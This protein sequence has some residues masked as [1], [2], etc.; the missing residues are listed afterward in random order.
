MNI[1]DTT[2]E[3]ISPNGLYAAGIETIQINIGLKCN[4]ACRHCH[5]ESS[6][7]KT[8][9]MDWETL[10]AVLD[11]AEMVNARIIDITGGA[12]EMHPDFCRFIEA[13]TAQGQDV[14]VRTNLTIMLEPG[15]EN[16][17]K[18]MRDHGVRLVA[19]LPCYLE[20]NV[21]KQRGRGVYNGSIEVI[22][23]LNQLG[24]GIDDDLELTLVYN[25]VGPVLPPRQE[26]LES[27][28]RR[29]LKDRFDISFTQLYTITNMPIGRF[30]SDL[31]RRGKDEEYL[32]TLKD[33]YNPS[34][35][36]GLM[37]RHQISVG[38][39][40]TLYDCDFNLAL[41]WP[42]NHGV[43]RNIKNFDPDTIASR[44]IVTGD[45]CFGCTA[46]AGSSCGG[47]LTEKAAG[48]ER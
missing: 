40:G 26:S 21:D 34:T 5:V 45:H 6:P 47:T 24:Y 23:K 30:L 27:D 1:F 28:Y 31:A 9:A 48:G 16:H 12:P 37:C 33:A 2:I 38:W 29:E 42:V 36:E 7:K 4:L 43:S 20:D 15:Y 19:S 46:G 32:Q 14:M 22:R 25:P 13:A 17:A 39:D 8:E 44:H 11:A 41:K 35:I 18:F 3:P 10:S